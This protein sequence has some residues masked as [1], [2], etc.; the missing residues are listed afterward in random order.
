MKQFL[1]KVREFQFASGQPTSEAPVIGERSDCELR[2]ELMIE[3]NEEYFD[4][5]EASSLIGTLDAVVDMAYVLFET[6][7]MHGLQDLFVEAFNLVHE[8]NM[9][10]V[11]DRK[12]IRNEFGKILKP[13]N[14]LPVDLK[15]LFNK[16]L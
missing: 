11:V 3:E 14:F 6:I 10:K 13:E 1:D 9:T 15:Q 2:L 7:N 5:T 8:N 16:Y 4:A 12:V